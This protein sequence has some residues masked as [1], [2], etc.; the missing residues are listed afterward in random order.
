MHSAGMT[1]ARVPACGKMG[2]LDHRLESIMTE[3]KTRHWLDLAVLLLLP[4]LA[5]GQAKAISTVDTNMKATA[6]LTECKRKEGILTIKVRFK[7]T[8]ETS[9]ELPYA[10]TY[11]IATTSG[12]KYEVLRDSD[13][14]PIATTSPYYSDQIRQSL[15]AGETFTAWWKFPAPPPETK[16]ITL[17]LPKS[18]PFEDVPITD[19]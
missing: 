13:K 5:R 10:E 15:K 1:V 8:A 17:L 2:L 4:G 6:E 9:I 12:K 14:R 11:V 7:A 18:E 3:L 16:K 19:Q